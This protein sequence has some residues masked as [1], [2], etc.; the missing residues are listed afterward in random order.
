MKRSKWLGVALAGAVALAGCGSARSTTSASMAIAEQRA[1]AGCLRSVRAQ[2]TL[3]T[4]TRTRLE[5]ICKPAGKSP[6]RLERVARE[7]CIAAVTGS[8]LPVPREVA[9]AHCNKLQ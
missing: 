4:G 3:T 8:R 2:G 9:L 6:I 7:A 5:A 1:L